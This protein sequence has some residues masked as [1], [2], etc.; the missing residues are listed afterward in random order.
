MAVTAEQVKELREKTGAG[1]MDCKQALTES[2]GDMEKAIDLLRAKGVD[3]AMK[4]EGKAADEGTIG[5][6]V[7]AGNQIGVLVELRCETD[8]VARTDD[9]REVARD[10]AMQIAA[11]Q[12]RW[13]SPDDVPEEV[14][15]RE[16]SVLREQAESE[17][18]PEHIVE[19]MVEGRLKKFYEEN[20]LLHQPFIRD[21]SIT[22]EDKLNSLI[23]ACG[24][25]VVVAR[26]VRFQVG[27]DD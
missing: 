5:A 19:K 21:D 20:C 26:F 7:H 11:M 10:L 18:K 13:I 12:P 15:E 3:V 24:E 25:R 2:G 6:Y 14:L 8:F 1:F 22:V 23:A 27:E 16:R 9:F 17:G 4:R